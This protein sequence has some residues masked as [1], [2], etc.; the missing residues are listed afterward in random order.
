MMRFLFLLMPLTLVTTGCENQVT[1]TV[2]STW[3]DGATKEIRLTEGGLP[4]NEIQQF[5]A[6]GLLHVRGRMVDGLREGTWNTYREDGVP[7]SQVDYMRGEKEGLFRTWHDN[8][9]PHIQGQHR[10]GQPSGIW[11]F[12]D[13]TGQPAGTRDFDAELME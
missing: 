7:W 3:P 13:V 4:G 1:E 10:G 8:G 5:H 6:N 11:H 9:L 2:V 12:F